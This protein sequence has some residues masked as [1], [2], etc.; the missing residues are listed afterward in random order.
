MIACEA[1][2]WDGFSK[3]NR[4]QIY[5]DVKEFVCEI[6]HPKNLKILCKTK[7]KLLQNHIQ[8]HLRQKMSSKAFLNGIRSFMLAE[9]EL[10]KKILP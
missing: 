7:T 1:V 6:H 10:W 9:A 4:K 2:E 3:F 5:G 8:N